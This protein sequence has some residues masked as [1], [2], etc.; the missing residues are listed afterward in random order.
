MKVKSV[1]NKCLVTASYLGA[2]TYMVPIWSK[3]CLHTILV[4]NHFVSCLQESY[5]LKNTFN[6]GRKW[7]IKHSQS[8][9]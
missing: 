3:D 6:F 4:P 7:G 8:I 9:G 1:R 2:A 5:F